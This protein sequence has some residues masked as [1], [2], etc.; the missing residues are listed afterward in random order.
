MRMLGNLIRDKVREG[1]RG[2]TLP[3]FDVEQSNLVKFLPNESL[4]LHKHSLA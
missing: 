3:K 4:R 2:F 1:R